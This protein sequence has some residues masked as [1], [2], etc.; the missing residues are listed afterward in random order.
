MIGRLL[1]KPSRLCT[2]WGR[3]L[4]FDGTPWHPSANR[5]RQGRP[6]P[7]TR[8]N[9]SWWKRGQRDGRGWIVFDRIGNSTSPPPLLALSPPTRGGIFKP[10]PAC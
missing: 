9:V 10:C 6:L 2:S 4:D 1:M 7:T 5:Q 3:L 8:D